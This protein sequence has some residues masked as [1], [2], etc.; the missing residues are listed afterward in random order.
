MDSAQWRNYR[1]HLIT[2]RKT[3]LG[4]RRYDVWRQGRL[5]ATFRDA[6]V[7]E[8]HIDALVRAGGWQ[9]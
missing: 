7:A 9:Q 1:G 6:V 5:V 4:L 3:F 2:T 8:L